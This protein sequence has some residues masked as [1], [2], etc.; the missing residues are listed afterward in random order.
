MATPPKPRRPIIERTSTALLF[1]LV[2]FGIGVGIGALLG[3]FRPP[4]QLPPTHIDLTVTP[5]TD[6]TL[7]NV[8]DHIEIVFTD[9]AGPGV[10]TTRTYTVDEKGLIPI[11]LIGSL[12]I[13]G[14]TARQAELAIAQRYK[15]SNIASNMPVQ[16]R[17]VS[18]TSPTKSP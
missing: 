9:L 17:R 2:I 3:K 13:R 12:E 6:P 15:D 11:P 1:L 18:A 16:V 10:K 7:F 4:I 8:G 5:S 14:H